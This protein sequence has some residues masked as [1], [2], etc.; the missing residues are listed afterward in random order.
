GGSGLGLGAAV[1][2]A[3]PMGRYLSASPFLATQLFVAGLQ[4]GGSDE[5][6]R[7]FLP[8]I[9]DG[10]IGTVALFE[11]DG[12]WN[13]AN[14][15]CEL[16][17][18]CLSGVKT[19]VTDAGVADCLLVSAQTSSQDNG[20]P[21]LAI[22]KKAALPKNAL[23]R[24]V[25]IDETHRSYR[26]DLDGVVVDEQ[27]VIRGDAAQR[28]LSAIRNAALLLIAAESSGGIAGV[29]NLVVEYLN[30]REA[31]GRKIGAYQGLKHPTV[32]V[33]IGL[34]RS[35]SHVYHAA[36]LIDAGQDAEVA[37][38]MA[39]AESSDAFAFAGD[40]AIQFHGGFGFTYECDAQ[41]YL[42]RALWSQY[43]FG[44]AAHHRKHLA[45]L[46]L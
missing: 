22:L 6:Q 21:V 31:F 42:R 27:N 15:Q 39:K 46:L 26:I 1:T 44:D 43:A 35:R 36:S 29:L 30:T 32:D 13:L 8:A 19:F 16:A 45:E 17:N 34:E 18:G 37:V 10:A 3:E 24:E 4:G 12:D 5:Q 14:A 40:R 33:L 25:V 20:G 23:V 7:R 9:A 41:L 28:A 38:R 11:E 2:I